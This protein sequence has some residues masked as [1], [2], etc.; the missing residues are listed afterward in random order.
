[1]FISGMAT[2]TMTT[3]IVFYA[4]PGFGGSDISALNGLP[5]SLYTGHMT[6]TINPTTVN[7][8]TFGWGRNGYDWLIPGGDDSP[9]LRT[10]TL[11]PPMLFPI[12]TGDEYLPYLPRF[13][14]AGGNLSNPTVFAPGGMTPACDQKTGVCIATGNRGALM[15]KGAYWTNFNKIW[16]GSD[17]FS[18]ILGNHSIKTGVYIEKNLKF[19]N[20]GSSVNGFYDF[21]HDAN[22]PYST[23]HG[24]AN[25]LLGIYTDLQ[26]TDQR[27]VQ[28]WDVVD[29]GRVRSGQLARKQQ[30]YARCRASLVPHGS[31]FGL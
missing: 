4:G 30:V 25:A 24:Y 6:H 8:V 17:D 22:N 9:Y 1:M 23:G 28:L 14:F 11:N 5:G 27:G 10:S 2:I 20:G 15:G 18:K 29:G 21:G 16:S 12:P 26:P 3:G 31:S 13:T 7:E 19:D